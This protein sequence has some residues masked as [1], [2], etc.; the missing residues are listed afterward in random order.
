[1]LLSSR[2]NSEAQQVRGQVSG[3]LGTHFAILVHGSCIDFLVISGL[4]YA[5][6]IVDLNPFAFLDTRLLPS[7]SCC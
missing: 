4:A 3:G 2:Q 6:A 7:N 1:M 5:R